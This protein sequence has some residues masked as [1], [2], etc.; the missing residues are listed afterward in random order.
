MLYAAEVIEKLNGKT[1][2]ALLN[3]RGNPHITKANMEIISGARQKV[4]VSSH[5]FN[6]ADES[7]KKTTFLIR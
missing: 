7:S 5:L 2:T 4:E 1:A 6:N 3:V